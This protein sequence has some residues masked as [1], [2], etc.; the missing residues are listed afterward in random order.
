M[1]WSHYLAQ[2]RMACMLITMKK[3]SGM[4]LDL[5]CDLIE[6]VV[7]GYRLVYNWGYS[8]GEGSHTPTIGNSIPL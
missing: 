4:A 8:H 3:E 6:C 7:T 1:T 2:C 5:G